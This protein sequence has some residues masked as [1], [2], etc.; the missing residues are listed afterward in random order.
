MLRGRELANLTEKLQ[1]KITKTIPSEIWKLSFISYVTY[2]FFKEDGDP[3]I[4][5][6]RVSSFRW[7]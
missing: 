1:L 4:F 2:I 3:S 5:I 7:C 6:D